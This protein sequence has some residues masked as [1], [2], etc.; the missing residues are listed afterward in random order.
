MQPEKEFECRHITTNTFDH[1]NSDSNS[2]DTSEDELEQGRRQQQQQR[3]I[4][5]WVMA[6][7]QKLKAQPRLKRVRLSW[8]S[9]ACQMS[10]ADA[11]IYTN[12]ELDQEF[13]Y[14]TM[15]LLWQ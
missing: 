11:S 8:P 3:Q 5:L 15:G 1:R 12:G 7:S 14:N 2:I 10:F 13:L 9:P 4:A 6:L